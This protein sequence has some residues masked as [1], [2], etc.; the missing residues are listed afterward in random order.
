[1]Y[2]HADP[3]RIVA[4]GT[5]EVV[6]RDQHR[7]GA[8]AGGAWHEREIRRDHVVDAI[9]A[10]DAFNAG[11]IAARLHGRS[12]DEALEEGVRCGAAV[13]GSASDTAGFPRA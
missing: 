1:L 12:I 4:R 5:R 13:T 7:V 10:G 3:G 11:Y 2:G 6:V 8:L 9:G